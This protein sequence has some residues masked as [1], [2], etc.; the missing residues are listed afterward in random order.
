[1]HERVCVGKHVEMH[2]Y[3]LFCGPQWPLDTAADDQAPR[4]SDAGSSG[5]SADLELGPKLRKI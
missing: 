1:M 3:A 5:E 4:F 2:A